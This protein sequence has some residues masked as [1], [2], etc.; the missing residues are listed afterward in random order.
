MYHRCLYVFKCLNNFIDH[1][2]NFLY[3]RDIHNYN[4][5]S[6]NRL[7]PLKVKRNWGKY[8]MNW[9]ALDEEIITSESLK[10][11]KSNFFKIM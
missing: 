4:T 3:N 2:I 1:D 5:R 6:K 8:M 11:F 10:E 9:N 7:R